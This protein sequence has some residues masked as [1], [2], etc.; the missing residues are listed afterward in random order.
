MRKSVLEQDV[1]ALIE[2][3]K[4]SDYEIPKNTDVMRVILKRIQ[5]VIVIQLLMVFCHFIIYGYDYEALIGI[6]IIS[7]VGGL[8]FSAVFVPSL[9]QLVSMMLSINEIDE[10][11]SLII[12]L[13]MGKLKRYWR[14]LVVINLIIGAVLLL[15]GEG[16][17]SGLGFSWF[18]TFLICIVSFQ[19]SLSRYMTPVVVSS[20]SKV[21]ELIFCDISDKK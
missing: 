4:E 18:V 16:V 9:Y 11:R 8:F 19:I 5:M 12:K 10:G 2:K 13:L 14:Y 17:I 7:A 20:L 6:S 15:S 21:R 1:S 3:I